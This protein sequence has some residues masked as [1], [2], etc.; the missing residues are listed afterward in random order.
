MP[1]DAGNRKDVRQAEKQAK[2]HEQQRKEIVT[3]IMSVRPDAL[4]CATFWNPVTS[5][6]QV[7]T[8]SVSEWLSW[9]DS[10]KSEF[11]CLPISWEPVP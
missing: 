10:V 5:S 4:G 3:G 7:I 6:R 9:K 2:L 11:G 8:M 1:Y